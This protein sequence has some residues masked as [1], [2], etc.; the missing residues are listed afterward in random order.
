MLSGL[1][2]KPRVCRV[3]GERDESPR[4]RPFTRSSQGSFGGAV[5]RE[6]TGTVERF[7]SK[8]R[9][10]VRASERKEREGEG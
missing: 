1:L 3:G 7:G 4:A 10:S 9:T 2:A 5:V 6:R 8:A